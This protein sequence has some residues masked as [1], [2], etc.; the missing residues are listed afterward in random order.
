MAERNESLS[1]P[2]KEVHDAGAMRIVV[3]SDV[4]CANPAPQPMESTLYRIRERLADASN[5]WIKYFAN[6][7]H[8][9]AEENP[10]RTIEFEISKNTL[11]S[12][13]SLS[14]SSPS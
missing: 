12:T 2:S 13:P 4:S 1:T 7:T 8:N 9:R 11:H 10:G 14:K 6:S 5:P 3:F